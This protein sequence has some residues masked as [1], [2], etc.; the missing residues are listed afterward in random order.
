[1]KNQNNHIC[2]LLFL[3]IIAGYP[4]QSVKAQSE[5][6]LKGGAVYTGL[7]LG[8]ESSIFDFQ[9]SSGF[10]L[11]AFYTRNNLIG[12]IGLQ[13]E[14]LYQM[15]GANIYIQ[16]PSIPTPGNGETEIVYWFQ[17]YRKGSILASTT[18][19][20]WDRHQERYHYFSLPILLTFQPAKFLDVYSGVELGYMFAK[21][22]IYSSNLN[23]LMLG[24]PNRFSASWIAGAKVRLGDKTKLDFRYSGNLIP[25]YEIRNTDIKDHSFSISIEQSLWRK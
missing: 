20:A 9:N 7:K 13:M 18:P 14:L 4:F 16:Q 11:G 22:N 12:P 17:Y 2:V 19:V 3:C 8:E 23:H 15:K 10:S 21:T 5:F 24:E 1:M 6:G 25:L